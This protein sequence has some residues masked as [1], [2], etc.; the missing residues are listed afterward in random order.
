[1]TFEQVL[2]FHTIVKS[3]SFKAAAVQL[4]K[5]QPAIS[6]SI[7]KLEEEME[8]DLFD[9]ESYRP[10]LTEHGNLFYEKSLKVLQGMNDLEDMSRGFRHKLEPEISIAIDGISPLSELLKLIKE[11][12]LRYPN[13]KLKLSF[14]T[15]SGAQLK[16]LNGEASV[17]ITH[18]VS[19]HH[20]LNILPLAQVKMIPVIEKK[21]FEEK[22]IKSEDDLK[23]I[24]QIVVEDKSGP[25]GASFGLLDEGKKWRISDGNFKREIILAGLGWGHLSEQ[26]VEA[27]I[28]KD[29][30][31]ILNFDNVHPRILPIYLIRHKKYQLGPIGSKLWIELSHF[32]K[33]SDV[34]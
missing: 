12:G 19:D 8:V 27:E 21:L 32:S 9:R 25:Q 10:G 15:L 7:K 14:E 6:L 31:V 29:K 2:V 17:G 11:F 24:D 30:L 1:M 5:T 20:L 26:A 28:K 4:N 34:T 33:Q 16:V 13:T 23:E 22:K 3:G 18:Y